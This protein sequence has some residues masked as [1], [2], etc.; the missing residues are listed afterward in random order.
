MITKRSTPG[1]RR[2]REGTSGHARLTRTGAPLLRSARRE[3]L[4]AW[5]ALRLALWPHGDPVALRTGVE[6]WLWSG[7]RD[8]HCI[9]AEED[10]ELLGFI[11]VSVRS[12][13]AGCEGPRVGYVEGWYVVPGARA[14]HVGRDLLRAGEAWAAARGCREFASGVA[15]GEAGAQQAHLACGFV[16][17]ARVVCYR[18]PVSVPG[19]RD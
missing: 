1:D 3:D 10:G 7:D 18:K 11:E 12:H 4:E 5:V 16:E 13:A 6:R 2:S 14:R 19:R 15:P 17:V 9:V 8:L